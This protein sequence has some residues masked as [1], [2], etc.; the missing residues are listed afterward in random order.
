MCLCFVSLAGA[1]GASGAE[2]GTRETDTPSEATE[3]HLPA[4]GSF[5]PWV[6]DPDIFAKDEGDRTEM[7]EVTE[8]VVKTVKLD[9][10]VP[11]IHFGL[12]EI[13]IPE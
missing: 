12:G 7:R 9:N 11:P 3:M 1:A 13:D 4:D 8:K 2:T 5:T 6:H 10:L